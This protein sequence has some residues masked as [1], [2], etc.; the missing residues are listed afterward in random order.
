M[1]FSSLIFLFVYLPVVLIGH[2]VWKHRGWQNTFL[3]FASLFFY[4]WG[5][6]ERIYLM[7]LS[8]LVNFYFGLGIER[9]T[10]H[11]RKTTYLTIAVV[12]NLLMLTIFKYTNFLVENV[13][14]LLSVGD[15]EPLEE[16]RIPLPIGISFYT[17]QALSYLVDVYRRQSA[18][19][20]NIIDLGLYISLFPQLIA[21]P[22]VRYHDIA[23]QIRQRVPDLPLFVSGIR[24]FCIGLGKKVLIANNLAPVADYVFGLP[25]GGYSTALAWLGIIAYS[26]QLYFDFSGYSDMAIGLGRM[27]GF[28]FLE[29][30]NYPYISRSIKEFWRR[31]HISLSH[32]FRDYLYISLG[33]NRISIRRTYFNLILV[34][35][36]TG[37]WHGA[38]WN[39]VVWGLFHGLFLILE[40]LGLDRLLAKGGR[41]VQ[42]GYTLLVVVVAWVFFRSEEFSFSLDYIATMFGAGTT[43]PVY[44]LAHVIDPFVVMIL[45]IGAIGSTRFMDWL[46]AR[47]QGIHL[48][49]VRQTGYWISSVFYLGMVA[50]SVMA[51]I[52]SA[53]NP[54]IYFRF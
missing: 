17:F 32:W 18:A 31:W 28:R 41:V 27:F 8:I 14:A 46:D 21:G 24:K 25:E 42:H 30:F 49:V 33:G 1:V 36:L 37:L 26:M 54:F 47:W 5:E 23:D 45:L 3:L 13:N 19:Q 16:T 7:A 35:F 20:R 22:I 52:N 11:A 9:A 38:S 39:F 29:N 2:Y 10:S 4:T 43:K 51:L 34:F 12:L 48:P 40:R 44:T 15:I 6:G 53:Y 50:L